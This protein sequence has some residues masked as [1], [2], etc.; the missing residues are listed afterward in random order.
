[1][2]QDIDDLNPRLLESML[3][4]QLFGQAPRPSVHLAHDQGI[5][6]PHLCQRQGPV[7]LRQLPILPA[8]V[9]C[10]ILGKLG[11]DGSAALL[12]ILPAHL[13]L[14]RDVQAAV[15]NSADPGI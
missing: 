14:V 11:R 2:L 5:E 10:V 15:V 8:G 4:P 9:P 7:D 6:R 12:G 1:M 13:Q 3:K